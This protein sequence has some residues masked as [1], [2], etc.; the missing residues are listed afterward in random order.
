MYQKLLEIALAALLVL[1]AWWYSGHTAVEAYKSQQ[2]IAQAK[3]TKLQ[4]DKYD[5]LAGKYETLRDTR[6]TNA[7]TI[8]REIEKV[9]DRPIYRNI[10]IDDAGLSL[11]NAALAGKGAS[12][13]DA[14]VQATDTP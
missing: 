13:T 2:E 6:A 3:A 11:A 7:K 12:S 9:V 1:G 5:E 4:Q 14:K 8:I 10:C